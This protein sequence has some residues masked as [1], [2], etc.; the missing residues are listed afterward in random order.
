M[1][2]FASAVLVLF[3]AVVLANVPFFTSKACVFFTLSRAKTFRL[4]L[5]ELLMGYVLVGLVAWLLERQSGQVAPQNW[6][7]FAITATL[8]ITFAFPGFVYQYL[9]K[10]NV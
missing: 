9:L 5:I 7:F 2:H 1:G 4:R 6:E 3:L 10:P 8:F